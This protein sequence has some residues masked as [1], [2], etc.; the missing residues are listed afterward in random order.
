MEAKCVKLILYDLPGFLARHPATAR[1]VPVPFAQTRP[2]PAQPPALG[3]CPLPCT[4][5]SEAE[6]RLRPT[7]PRVLLPRG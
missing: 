4:G 5:A 3:T 7:R 1:S 6:H 2:E